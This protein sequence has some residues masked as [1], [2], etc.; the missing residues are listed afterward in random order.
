M[1]TAKLPVKVELIGG[2]T[3]VLLDLLAYICCEEV[4]ISYSTL[5]QFL[6]FM[7]NQ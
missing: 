6:F 3:S 2:N 1:N 7:N 5:L 4:V